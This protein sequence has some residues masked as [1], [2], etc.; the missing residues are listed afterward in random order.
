MPRER[1]PEEG[2]AS[3]HQNLGVSGLGRRP[4]GYLTPSIPIL[5]GRMPER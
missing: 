1:G 2:C 4:A 5:S 3:E